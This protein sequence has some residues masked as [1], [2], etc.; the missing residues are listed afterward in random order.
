MNWKINYAI[1]VFENLSKEAFSKRYWLKVPLFRH[2]A[3]LLYSHRYMKDGIEGALRRAFGVGK[4]FGST[5]GTWF[6]NVK[7]G[8][9]ASASGDHRPYLLANYSRNATEGQLAL[10]RIRSDV[11]IA[12][13][14]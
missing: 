1:S 2:T 11:V 10:L 13:L 9:I 8:V 6:E 14:D 7:V 5:E 3:Q 4:L 12:N